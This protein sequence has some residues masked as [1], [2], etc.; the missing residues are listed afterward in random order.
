MK[1]ISCAKHDL[2]VAAHQFLFEKTSKDYSNK[3]WAV[4]ERNDIVTE[5][6]A[7]V[8]SADTCDSFFHI[9]LKYFPEFAKGD[10]TPAKLRHMLARFSAVNCVSLT[11]VS[12]YSYFHLFI[13]IVSSHFKIYINFQYPFLDIFHIPMST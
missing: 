9:M 11:E 13:I 4:T 2:M 8:K 5:K 7:I 6:Q 3:M 1:L 12:N 10:A